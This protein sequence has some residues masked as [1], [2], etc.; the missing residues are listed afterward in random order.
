MS[1]ED[2]EGGGGRGGRSA[3]GAE[4]RRHSRCT[5]DSRL[6]AFT[7]ARARARAGSRRQ[8]QRK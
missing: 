1:G 4:A 3:A 8:G 5:M 6:V 2:E 7:P